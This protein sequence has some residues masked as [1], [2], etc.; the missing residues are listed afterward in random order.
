MRLS[1]LLLALL[2][3]ACGEPLALLP[4]DARLPDGGHYRGSIIDGRLQ[5]PGRIDYAN[6]AFSEGLFNSGQLQGP[7][8][9]RLASGDEFIGEFKHGQPDGLG[10][11]R[12]RSGEHYIG[13]FKQGQFS[14]QGVL[15]FTGGSYKGEFKEGRYHG[16]G[17]LRS[18]DGS[19]HQGQFVKGQPQ[20][21]GVRIDAQGQ[22]FSGRFLKGELNGPG[23]FLGSDGAFYQ[24]GFANNQFNGQGRYIVHGDTWSGRFVDGALSGAGEFRGANGRLYRGEFLDWQFHGQGRLQSADGAVYK[25]QFAAGEYEGRGTLS[26]P[27]QPPQQGQWAGGRW[28]RDARGKT[29]SDPLELALLTQGALLAQA[30]AAVAPS[31][32]Q[33]ELYG[34]TVAGDGQQSVFLREVAFVNRQLTEQF[35]A[36]GLISLVNHRDHYSDKLMATQETLRRS[37]ATLATRS[38][39]EDLVL[40]YMTSH[41]SADHQFVLEQPRLELASLPAKELKNLLAPLKDRHKILIISACYSGGFI[42]ALKDDKTLIVA[43]ARHDRT[44]F[45]CSDDSDFTYFGKA[46]MVDALTETRDLQKAF[47]RAKQHIAKREQANGFEPSEPQLWAPPAVLA[48]WNA[49]PLPPKKIAKQ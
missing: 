10:Q 4:P 16:L 22:R 7:G 1:P 27:N 12:Y 23:H 31:T 5:G 48:K 46:L 38:G 14:G 6:G 39:P 9:R 8:R 41:G 18:P 33:S 13:R 42:P 29:V 35:G 21:L 45:G 19:R 15:R 11:L 20:G 49:L 3:S 34:L 47:T 40:I 17:V 37:I 32:P 2:L 28:L 25:G 26:R 24:G 36:R 30:Q 43:A 44:S